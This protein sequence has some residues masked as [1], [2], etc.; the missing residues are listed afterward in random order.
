MDLRHRTAAELGRAIG[1][2]ELDPVA[3]TEAFL[4]AIAAHPDAGRIYSHVTAE[5]ARAE[6]AGAALRAREGRRLSPLDGVPISWKDLFDSAGAPTEAGT[7][8]MRGRVPEHDARALQLAREAGLVCLGKTHLSEI[9]FSG[10]GYNPVTA[11][12]PNATDREAVPGGSS[13][14]AAASVAFDLAVAA[15]GTDTGGSIRV[16]A[17]WNDLVGFKP[18]HGAVPMEGAVA[19]CR[20]FDT[21]GPLCR[22]VEDAALLLAI[23]TGQPA[24]DLGAATLQGA[25]LLV[26]EAIPMEDL[27]GPTSAAFDSAVE[28]FRAAGAEVIRAPLDMIGPAYGLSPVLYAPEAWAEWR[29][30][31]EPDPSVMFPEIYERTRAGADVTAADYIAGWAEL[32]RHREAYARATAGFDAVICPT[33]QTR[34]PKLDAIRAS[35]DAYKAAN[36]SALRNTRLANLMGLCA[37]SLPT[38]TAACGVMLNAAAGADRRL[39]RLAKAAE[40]ALA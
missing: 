15:I 26:P 31:I 24:P 34:P 39:L 5:R 13:S 21:G 29:A 11:T 22:S 7:A 32:R 14:G 16:P 4:D 36:L 27:D 9:A 28:R 12:P 10:L 20:S 2:G 40:T 19:L 17:G 38:G 1:A 18:T 6:A 30:L 33:T 3:L 8:L 37:V 35:S 25:R 23:L